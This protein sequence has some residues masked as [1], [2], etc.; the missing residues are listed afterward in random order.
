MFCQ[1]PSRSLK[2]ADRDSMQFSELHTQGMVE[3]LVCFY[4]EG[5]KRLDYIIQLGR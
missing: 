3:D 1:P 2:I 4:S 5:E